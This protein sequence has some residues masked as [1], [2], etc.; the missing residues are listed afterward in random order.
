MEN[1]EITPA[2]Q[3]LHQI[4][5]NKRLEQFAWAVFLIF[6][7]ILMLLPDRWDLDGVWLMGAG[8]VMLGLNVVRFKYG[9]K[10]GATTAILG[11]I[12]I[13][14]GIDEHFYLDFILLPIIIIVI[15]FVIIVKCLLE[16]ESGTV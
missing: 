8:V 2:G 3:S 13:I 12:A 1:T 5:L 7:G 4:A 16:K 11:I 15:G 6:I 10:M 9:I 14:L